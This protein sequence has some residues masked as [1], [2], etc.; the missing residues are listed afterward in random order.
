MMLQE[1]TQELSRHPCLLKLKENSGSFAKV[2]RWYSCDRE[3]SPVPCLT[4][5]ALV[6]QSAPQNPRHPKTRSIHI[7]VSGRQL[8]SQGLGGPD[9]PTACCP[10]CVPLSPSAP[11]SLL[12]WFPLGFQRRDIQKHECTVQK[13][14]ATSYETQRTA[15]V[16][17]SPETDLKHSPWAGDLTP[18]GS[19]PWCLS[20]SLGSERQ[21]GTGCPKA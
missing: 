7:H 13:V 1:N 5:Q 20:L 14:P 11:Y 8:G 4:H 19:R 12:L 15:P 16:T 17:A 3:T 6:P 21:V 18:S 9:P 2:L 10:A